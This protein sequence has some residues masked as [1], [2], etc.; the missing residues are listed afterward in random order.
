M[1]VAE[2][3]ENILSALP[4][5]DI[6]FRAQQV[7]K[8]WK[9]VVATSPAIQTK[10]WLKSQASKP[11]SPDPL[12]ANHSLLSSLWTQQSYLHGVELRPNLPVYSGTLAFN[13]LLDDHHLKLSAP[14]PWHCSS[15]KSYDN[16]GSPLT[17][18]FDIHMFGELNKVQHTWLDMYLTE[19]PVT[20]AQLDVSLPVRTHSD[21]RYHV[22]HELLHEPRGLTFRTT[23]DRVEQIFQSDDW[24]NTPRYRFCKPDLARITV[25]LLAE[26]EA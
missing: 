23:M 8:D 14:A 17:N 16:A 15:S 21:N 10:L 20:T 3:L 4:A 6:I 25:K 22:A 24:R 12:A 26:L 18:S 1:A 2:L 19:P 11:V 13:P 5:N 7:C 9:D